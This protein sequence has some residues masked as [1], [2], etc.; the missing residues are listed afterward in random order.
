MN[1]WL[2]IVGGLIIGAAIRIIMLL[3]DIRDD[4]RDRFK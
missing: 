3:E 4:A 2:A 1:T